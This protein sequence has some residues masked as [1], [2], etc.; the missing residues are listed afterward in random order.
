MPGTGGGQD[1]AQRSPAPGLLPLKL[2]SSGA[3]DG[4][5][6]EPSKQTPLDETWPCQFS[7]L[8]SRHRPANFYTCGLWD[9]G[10]RGGVRPRS[11]L[12]RGA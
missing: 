10:I 7:T 8:V 5:Q 9:S 6:Q 11:A 1:A 3:R 12:L 2:L 4:H